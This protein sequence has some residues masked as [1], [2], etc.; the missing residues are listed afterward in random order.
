MGEVK[1][2]SLVTN[3]GITIIKKDIQT[4]RAKV[5]SQDENSREHVLRFPKW[6]LSEIKDVLFWY[7]AL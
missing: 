6:L 4:T 1:V 2:L 7:T 5:G 3:L